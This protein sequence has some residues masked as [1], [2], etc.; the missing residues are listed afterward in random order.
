MRH[1]MLRPVLIFGV[2]AATAHAQA[3]TASD[4][5]VVAWFLKA[6]VAKAHGDLSLAEA[7]YG[8]VTQARP[9]LAEARSNLGVVHYLQGRCSDAVSQF[10]QAL[11]LKPELDVPLLFSGFC[12]E[13]MYQYGKAVAILERA[14]GKR[15]DQS[16]TFLH[17]GLSYT[18]LGR[19]ERANEWFER[20]VASNPKD[21]QGL[22]QLGG[23]YLRLASGQVE[24]SYADR[25]IFARAQAEIG[26]LLSRSGPTLRA[27]YEEAISLQP[28]YP[29]LHWRLARL[30]LR[31]GDV[32]HAQA[33][34]AQE[35]ALQPGFVPALILMADLQHKSGEESGERKTL[36]RVGTLA[37]SI[38]QDDQ[39]LAS[40]A[41]AQPDRAVLLLDVILEM[42]ESPM[43]SVAE[44]GNWLSA[45]KLDRTLETIWKRL[46]SH[47]RED[48]PL[49]VYA[50]AR[51][52]RGETRL[53][54]GQL[55]L[56]FK[57]DPAWGM[58]HYVLAGIYQ[59][60]SLDTYTRMAEVDLRSFWTLLLK[61]ETLE[62]PHPDSDVE[63]AYRDASRERP[64]AVGIH[65]RLG[66]LL[67][68][69][70]QAAD[71]IAEFEQELATDLYNNSARASL[72]EAYVEQRQL[73]K[74]IPLLLRAID[75]DAKTPSAYLV[76]ARAYLMQE[77]PLAAATMFE[78]ALKLA[79]ENVNAHYQLAQTY[80]ELG[81]EGEAAREFA[82]V[83]RLRAQG[84]APR[85]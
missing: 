40:L 41:Q 9:D 33:A 69:K 82:T 51:M 65:L 67:L 63:E 49:E 13:K 52:T 22:Y 46:Q 37:Q 74:A 79:P 85:Q 66:Q 72:G 56:L 28:S 48:W 61:A 54:R 34:L 75:E 15:P 18:G 20:F 27:R 29:A 68:K 57:Q 11:R 62:Y 10:Q 71:A 24:Q 19:E 70:H 23:S 2:L 21:P 32:P 8:R 73:E 58:P 38:P 76:L 55:E 50:R 53:L 12:Y 14:L 7:Y 43:K 81:R 6:R 17:L 31:D 45:D 3:T 78:R 36:A 26:E 80:Q 4:D 60:L 16:E 84:R 59:K 44:T 83:K 77:R 42:S 39:E 25:F 1:V 30:L 5:E 47:P 35:L 64:G